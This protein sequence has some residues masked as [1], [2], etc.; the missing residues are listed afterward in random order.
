MQVQ[1][2]GWGDPLKEGTATPPIFL[3]GES[4]GQ[5]SLVGYSPQGPKESNMTKHVISLSHMYLYMYKHTCILNNFCNLL[6]KCITL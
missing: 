2:L 3:L 5:R 4:H 1:S 6:F